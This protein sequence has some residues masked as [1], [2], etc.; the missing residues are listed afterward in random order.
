MN[1]GRN[2]IVEE[3]TPSSRE[4]DV[5]KVLWKLGEASVREVRE[6]LCPNGECAFTTV[7]TLLRI[8]T[9]KGFVSQRAQGR[10]MYY[11]PKYT[12]K[13]AAARFLRK[14]FDGSLENLVLSMLQSEKTS[15]A[16]LKKMEQ[17]IADARR[18]KLKPPKGES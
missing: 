11:K 15:D 2:L 13:R 8:M 18:K 17:M 16:E 1:L 10:T 9:D 4:I 5:L 3:N 6:V 12:Q 14:V 7:Q